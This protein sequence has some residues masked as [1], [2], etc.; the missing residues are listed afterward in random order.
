MYK[1]EEIKEIE[2]KYWILIQ[3][4]PL[5]PDGKG[6]Q[7]GDRGYINGIPIKEVREKDKKVWAITEK[8]PD[9]DECTLEIDKERRK[10]IAVQH[11]AQHILSAAFV[12]KGD[13]P[14]VSFHMGEEYSTI[15][16]DIGDV[17]EKTMEEVLNLANETVRACL[18]VKERFVTFEEAK[19]LPLRRR[20]S[21]K[22]T[23]EDRIRLI[24][25]P[26]YDLAACGG[27]HVEN[28][29]NIGIISI[30]QKEKVKG[31]LTRIYF[32]AGKRVDRY[33]ASLIHTA[34]ILSELL[35]VP[36]TQLPERVEKI[37]EEVK[38]QKTELSKVGKELAEKIEKELP[39]KMIRNV[40]IRYYE[41]PEY[42]ASN[43]G[44]LAQSQ[45]I[46]IIKTGDRYTIFSKTLPARDIV[47]AIR[48]EYPDIKGGGGK[49]QGNFVGKA[50]L[51]DIISAIEALIP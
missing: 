35:K 43:M 30:I 41:G 25:I 33:L 6:G 51:N 16:L 24:E 20:L 2:G 5:Y 26:G 14:T 10:D 48:K 49:N 38:L 17:S 37:L 39:E 21:D 34:H 29:G 36:H 7:I 28:T 42:I 50:S 8:K 18:P 11:T 32:I 47:N 4:S 19:K 45:D 31:K 9:G 23:K 40:K 12:K 46:L 1:F 27:F 13:M 15:D 44:K 3:D 22:L